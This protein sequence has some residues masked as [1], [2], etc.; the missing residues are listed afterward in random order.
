MKTIRA[1]FENGVFRPRE[2]VELP[3]GSQ[4]KITLQEEPETK[5]ERLRDRFPDSI[6]T[7]SETDALELQ[8]IIDDEFR[9]VNPD[10]WK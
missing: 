8:R 6:G 3:P 5:P 9:R 1:V 4:V 2:P 7:L 10:E